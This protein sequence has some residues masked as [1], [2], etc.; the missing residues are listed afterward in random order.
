MPETCFEGINSVLEETRVVVVEV[1]PTEGTS[2]W[3]YVLFVG[4]VLLVNLVLFKVCQD[5][6]RK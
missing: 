1:D 5:W 3:L 2:V 4:V 6:K